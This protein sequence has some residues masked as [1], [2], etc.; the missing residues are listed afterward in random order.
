MPTND[1]AHARPKTN[2]ATVLASEALATVAMQFVLWPNE[3]PHF[4]ALKR[5]T[6]LPNRS[7]QNELARL[8]RLEMVRRQPDGRLVRYRAQGDHAGWQGVR[9]LVAAFAEP[10]DVVRAAVTQIPGVDAAFIY[11]S[12]ARGAKSDAGDVEVMVVGERVNDSMTKS[13]LAASAIGAGH[14]VGREVHV[15][16][17]TPLRL[18]AGYARGGRFVCSVLEGPKR[19]VVGSEQVLAALL[20][21]GPNT[22][23]TRSA[24]A[25]VGLAPA[26]PAGRAKSLTRR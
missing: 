18:R 2:L 13:S 15:V 25:T 23:E 14:L 10:T 21:G 4:Q 24:S 9:A 26:H 16:R 7:L 5:A 1:A 8:E 20:A 22:C 19:W 3:A 6:G 17:Y 12:Y 11:G